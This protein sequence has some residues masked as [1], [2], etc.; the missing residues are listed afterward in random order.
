MAGPFRNL[1]WFP[2]TYRRPGEGESRKADG[3]LQELAKDLPFFQETATSRRGW[4]GA[5]DYLLFRNLAKD[6]FNSEYYTYVREKQ[7]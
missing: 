2:E 5:L 1:L 4:H 7:E 6:W 3:I